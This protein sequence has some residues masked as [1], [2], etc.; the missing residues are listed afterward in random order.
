MTHLEYAR[1]MLEEIHNAEPLIHDRR[2]L[3]LALI[4]DLANR[5]DGAAVPTDDLV[6]QPY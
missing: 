6:V 1:A 5:L 4:E 2:E 3:T